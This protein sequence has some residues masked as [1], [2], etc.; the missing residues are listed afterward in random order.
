MLPKEYD[1][2]DAFRWDLGAVGLFEVILE[3]R[4]TYT[5]VY[6][7]AYRALQNSRWLT[8]FVVQLKLYH[9]ASL[10]EVTAYLTPQGTMQL[11]SEPAPN[12]LPYWEKWQMNHLV[13]DALLCCLN[14][15]GT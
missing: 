10:A 8:N 2:G 1:I 3:T 6:R 5:D 9:D 11:F 14:H 4:Q 13:C 12:K 7:V 15:Q